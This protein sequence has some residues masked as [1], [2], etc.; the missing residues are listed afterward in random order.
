MTTIGLKF[1]IHW[2]AYLIHMLAE[3]ITFKVRGMRGLNHL[4]VLHNIYTTNF[5][6]KNVKGITSHVD[7]YSKTKTGNSSL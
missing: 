4:L 7:M 6:S 3:D 5:N 2:I 1:A